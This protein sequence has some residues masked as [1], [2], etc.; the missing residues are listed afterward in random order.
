MWKARLL[1]AATA[2]LT[3]MPLGNAAYAADAD[4]LAKA[5]GA[6]PGAWGM[7]LSPDGTRVVYLTPVGNIG[8][9]IVVAEIATGASKVVLGTQGNTTIPRYC[10]WKTDKR[11]ICT[12]SGVSNAVED[13]LGFS[14]TLAVDIDGGNPKTLGSRSNARTLTIIQN[15][16]SVIDWLPDDPE[17]V[18]M[19][20]SLA[21]E[22]TTGTRLANTDNGLSVQR[23]NVNTG[24]ME[25]VEAGKTNIVYYDT[26]NHGAVRLMGSVKTDNTGYFSN[27]LNYFYRTQQ[28]K[29][30]RPAGVGNLDGYTDL[31][32][33][34]FDATGRNLLAFKPKD[35]RLALFAVDAS[36]GNAA[37]T[38]IFAHPEVDVDGVLRIGKFRRP[39][40]VGYTVEA[41]RLHYFDADLARLSAALGKAL[42]GKP[43]VEVLDESWDGGKKL[44]FAGSDVD[45]GRYYRFDTGSKELGELVA[46]RPQ[47]DKI[48]LAPMQ[49]VTIKAGDGT[50][51]P[52]FLTLPPDGRKTGLPA[53]IM[54]H[55]GPSARDEWGFDWLSQYFAQLG[56][57]VLQPNYRGSA[58]YGQDYYVK[59][60]FQSWP[61]A[62]GD[63]NDSARWLAAQGIADPK[64]T[65]IFGWSYGGYAALQAAITDPA[66]YKAVVAIAPVT[67]LQAL[68]DYARRFSNY[69]RIVEFV[70]DGPL[71]ISG[72]PARNAA[73]INAPVLIFHGDQ[74]INVDLN[75][76]QLMDSALVSAGKVHELVTYTGLDHQLDDSKARADMLARSA[77]FLVANMGAP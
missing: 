23:V 54:P 76:S 53:I 9:A 1:V 44:I 10:Q 50:A 74:D 18:L 17:L 42:P 70:G 48:K 49:S 30:W 40:A 2:M 16:G 59:N 41:S 45:P 27:E 56:Y 37:D 69:A 60:G 46:L 62:I 29:D 31:A 51:I 39:V 61:T 26:D 34:G 6:R 77:A 65:A 67:D 32:Y 5:F 3:L 25:T 22:M 35:G 63:I 33:D 11:L 58:G 55:G 66:L 43:I 57:A 75:Q 19:Q 20:V 24:R 71:T 14:R 21:P 28:L 8:T 4:A 68:K 72:S 38:L 7:R 36:G 64:R 13:K 73:K 52:A 12:L 15:S 47:L